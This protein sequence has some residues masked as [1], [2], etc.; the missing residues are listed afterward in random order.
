MSIENK[1]IGIVFVGNFIMKE[2]LKYELIKLKTNYKADIIPI[3]K[4]YKTNINIDQI[5]KITKNEPVFY[6]KGIILEKTIKSFDF[7]ILVGCG[8]DIISKIANQ[9]FDNNI[10]KLIKYSQL[11]QIP[12]IIGINIKKFNYLSLMNIENLYKNKICF[13]I[14]FKIA[15]PITKPDKISFDPGLFLKTISFASNSIQIKPIL[16]FL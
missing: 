15:N 6:D 8:D 4:R 2:N 14:P 11:K 16:N 1:T 12:I 7:L 3:I 9:K 13:F 10:L 5:T